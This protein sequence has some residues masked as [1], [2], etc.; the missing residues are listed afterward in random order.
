[1]SPD[2]PPSGTGG[3]RGVGRG[4]AAAPAAGADPCRVYGAGGSM[5]V[6]GRLRISWQDD[7]TLKIEMDAGTQTRLIRFNPAGPAP[8]EKTLQGYSVGTWELAGGGRGGRGGGGGG[9][10][11]AP[12]PPRW[13]SLNVAT[14][15][16]TAGY[17][18]SSRSSYSENATLTEYFTKHF[19]VTT[20]GFF[21]TPALLCTILQLGVDRVMFSVDWP[22][23]EAPPA[24]DWM[25]K[26]PLS[27]EEKAKIY[28]GNAKRLL[29]L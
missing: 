27:A 29:K 15:N 9:G 17:L 24:M 19:W 8:T 25:S 26:I 13:G 23:N 21:S 1:M 2:S 12:A 14:T 4:G 28:G 7:N 20:S 18:L 5:R 3:A 10:A 11:A 16:M 22:M 6:P